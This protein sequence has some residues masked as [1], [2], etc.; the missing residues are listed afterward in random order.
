MK[1]NKKDYAVFILSHGRAKE[2]KTVKTLKKFGYTGEWFV[3][4]DDL[5]KQRWLYENKFDKN[6]LIIFD[7]KKVAKQTDTGDNS[8]ELNVGVF[9][10]NF[11][12]DEAGRR[13][14]D[15]HVQL[16]DDFTGFSL[17][18]IKGDKIASK[19]CSDIDKLFDS[20]IEYLKQ[21]KFQVL[22]F[23]L[24]SDYLGGVNNK[25]YFKGMFP[26]TMGTF[27]IKTKGCK[28][29]CMRMNDDVTTGA[30]YNHQGMLYRTISMVQT[31]TQAT[32]TMNG[33]MTEVYRNSGTYRKAFYS[34]MCLPS[35]AKISAMGIVDFR[36]HHRIE[37]ETC[38]PK[39]VSERY[40]K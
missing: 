35:S 32:Q 34:V 25:K 38:T 19:R 18:Y 1:N 13:G 21:T 10:R 11:I 28:K 36:I 37:W 30:L 29:F 23:A 24:S 8:D 12:I 15:Y 16:D 5:D 40:K 20:V 17:R 14:Y 3:V 22:S 33:G 6:H 7:K 2:I 39:I 26:K 27:F 9:A 4:I 31:E